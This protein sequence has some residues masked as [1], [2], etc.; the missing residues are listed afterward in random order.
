MTSNN[1]NGEPVIRV[2]NL[3]KSF[4]ENQVLRGISFNLSKGQNLVILGRSGTGKSV[5]IKCVV[6]LMW[7]D[8]GSINVLGQDVIALSEYELN[9][10]RI[11]VGYLF[12]EGALYDS[13]SLEENLLFPLK[14]N[15]PGLPYKEM[16]ELIRVALENVDLSEASEKMPSE[17]SGGMRKRASL[18]R[19]L[20]LNPEIILYDEPTTGLDPYT[21]REISELIVRIQEKYNAS[22]IVVTHDLKC[23]RTVSDQISILHDGQFIANGSFNDLKN[24]ENP[25]VS[26]YFI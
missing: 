15:R 5:L 24:H 22:S 17:L 12:Q 6:R 8:A 13:M 14:R 2:I 9:E 16:Q 21:S 7:P 11:R 23:A 20:I 18:A 26:N 19:T 4:D 1:L 25:I 10:L 3:H